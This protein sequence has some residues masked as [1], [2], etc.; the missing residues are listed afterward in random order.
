MRIAFLDVVDYDYTPE[1]VY[2]QPLGGS[3]SAICYLAEELVKQGQEVFL[4]NKTTTPGV[5]FGVTCLPFAE[6]SADLRRSLDVLVVVNVA[7]HG[8]PIR[9]VLPEWTRLVL[10]SQHAHD[11]PAIQGLHR[12]DEC[13]A[14]DGFALV[15]EWQSGQY[16]RHFALDCQRIQVLRNGISPVFQRDVGSASIAIRY[17]SHPP[18]LAYTSTPFRGLDLLLDAFPAIRRAIPGAVLKVFSSM[19]VYNLPET[20]YGALYQQCRE[21]EGVE[22]VGSIPQP[23]LAE[24][25]KAVSILAYPNTFAETSCIAV[26]EAMAS[27][28]W[29]VTSDLGALP[30]TT[31]GF[32]RLI[33]TSDDRSAYQQHFIDAV[34]DTVRHRLANPNEVEQRLEQ[35]VSYVNQAYRW[36]VRAKEW[37][38]W[39]EA[40]VADRDRSTTHAA[41]NHVQQQA[42][43]FFQQQ[44]YGQATVLYRQLLEQAP[45]R[46]SN[47]WY[48]GLSL[49]LQGD[50]DEAQAVW[51]TALVN[52]GE[53]LDDRLVEL[54]SL[55]KNECERQQQF[56]NAAAV[57]RLESCLQALAEN[58]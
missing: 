55:L 22:Y 21:T 51:M 19:K 43:V 44:N 20:D 13:A 39:L 12:A 18:I 35:Q 50:V 26:M 53:S 28:C 15:S 57:E 42:A 5:F 4:L 47:Y 32:A 8:R 6:M 52:S 58:F 1:T 17:K 49:L 48:L 37:M 45:N 16:Q 40:L 23:A 33:P 27:G 31:A 34:I 36:S 56:A 30:E 38:T 3:S 24:E 10:W 2:Y 29:V 7:S 11:Q 9:A 41:I 54:A 14:Y 46:V 25:L